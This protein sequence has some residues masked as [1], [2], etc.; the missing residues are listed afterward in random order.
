[1]DETRYQR[2]TKWIIHRAEAKRY[3]DE[4]IL[5]TSRLSEALNWREAVFGQKMKTGC[6]TRHRQYLIGTKRGAAQDAHEQCMA[7][8]AG[9]DRSF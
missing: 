1:M 7:K 8:G 6:G 9:H 5:D 3:P 4:L 2:F